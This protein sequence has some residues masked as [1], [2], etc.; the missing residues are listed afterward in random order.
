M[1]DSQGCLHA[2]P[3]PPPPTLPVLPPPV[4][5]RFSAST[6]HLRS[7]QSREEGEAC[8]V[9]EAGVAWWAGGR[10]VA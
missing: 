6:S 9:G 3:P 7:E 10:G 4:S 8:L 5:K 2:P 1:L